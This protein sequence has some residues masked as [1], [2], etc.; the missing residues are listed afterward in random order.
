MSDATEGADELG[1]DI[2]ESR[3]NFADMFARQ[4][5]MSALTLKYTLASNMMAAVHAMQKS[6][7]EKIGQM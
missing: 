6:I 1:P 5:E 4:A 3:A 7:A 2:E